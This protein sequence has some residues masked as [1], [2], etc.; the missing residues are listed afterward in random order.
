MPRALFSVAGFFTAAA[1]GSGVATPMSG[2][3]FNVPNILN[4]N[5]YLENIWVQGA[6][7]DW[8]SVRSPKMQDN[9]QGIRLRTLGLNAKPLLPY[10]VGNP[11]YSGDTP[12]VTIDENAI[13]TGA[14]AVT[15]SFD[16]LP[17]ANPRLAMWRDIDSRVKNIMGCD[18]LVSA[19]AAI[20]QYSP[21][22]AINSAFDNFKADTDYALIGCLTSS[23]ALTIAVAGQDTGNL[24]VGIPGVADAAVTADYLIR[25]SERSG[26]PS[27]PIIAANNKGGTL[28]FQTGNAALAAQSVTLLLAELG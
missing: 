6:A 12:T 11:M 7:T 26:R 17:G 24:K 5:A 14:V 3:T 19:V 21:G 20:G 10:D 16:D 23:T 4:G 1:A 13:A 9:N 18:V 28:V 8:V 25:F 27:I 2:D 15:Y 22:V